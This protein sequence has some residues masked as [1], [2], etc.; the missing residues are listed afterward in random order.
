MYV[1]YAPHNQSTNFSSHI[2][3][4]FLP[5]V[6]QGNIDLLVLEIPS[7]VKWGILILYVAEHGTPI[8][9]HMCEQQ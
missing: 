6:Q 5:N 7:L 9:K 2:F 8:R 1:C 3:L 4:Q